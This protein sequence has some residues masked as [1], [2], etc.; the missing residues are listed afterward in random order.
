[1]TQHR[2]RDLPPDI[3]LRPAVASDALCLGVLATQVFL[4]TYASEGI[5]AAIA[6]EVLASF[7][8][9]TM[10]SLIVQGRSRLWVAERVGHLIGFAQMTAG[11]TQG[12][13][14]T[15]RPAELDRLYVQEP[16]TRS[17]VGSALLRQAERA[18]A[19]HRCTALWLTP[20][21]HNVRAL[22]FYARH[23]YQNL[24]ITTF[25]MDGEA[26]ENFVLAKVLS[27]S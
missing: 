16:F 4:D 15:A 12:L 20:W 18:A 21:V 25:L 17:G 26:I 6:R 11:T 23:A 5:R 22:T 2:T 7:S 14:Q 10:H 3:A 24:G 27:G 9:A 8:T 1:M 19:G 13:V